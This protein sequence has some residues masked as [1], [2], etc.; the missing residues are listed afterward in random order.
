VALALRLRLARAQL[1]DDAPAAALLDTGLDEL[2]LGL[3]ELRELARGIHPAILTDQGLHAALRGLVSRAPVPV[4]LVQLPEQRLPPPVETAAYFLIAEAL[5]N[6]AK[7]AQA[8]KATVSVVQDDGHAVVEISD[9][10][11][12][13]ADPNTGSGLRGLSDRIEALHGDLELL[14]PPG[15][16]TTVRARMPL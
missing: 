3:K 5:T 13:G 12:G 11:V 14:S 7:Y 15:E 8:T 10:G 16:G 9:D 2:A 4:E 6:V 1:P